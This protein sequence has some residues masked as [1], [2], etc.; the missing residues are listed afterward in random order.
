MLD[1]SEFTWN[2]CHTLAGE[3]MFE[4]QCLASPVVK[5]LLEAY[6]MRI[7]NFDRNCDIST[8]SGASE[9]INL[10]PIREVVDLLVLMGFWSLLGQTMISAWTKICNETI[11]NENLD[12][13]N[14]KEFRGDMVMIIWIV[15]ETTGVGLSWC[16]YV[17]LDDVSDKIMMCTDACTVAR[18]HSN[19]LEGQR[20]AH[21]LLRLYDNLHDLPDL[22]KKACLE[23][24]LALLNSKCVDSEDLHA[25]VRY[26]R[27]ACV[28]TFVSEGDIVSQEHNFQN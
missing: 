10:T 11:K 24:L 28:R 18:P 21:C 16:P 13:A 3:R 23:K 4:L 20:R 1:P 26:K 17:D 22:L 19:D 7:L 2:G 6:L 25:W 9:L 8:F 14:A 5:A 27:L 12:D 15:L